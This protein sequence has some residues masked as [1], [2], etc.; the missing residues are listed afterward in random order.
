L[1]FLSP[2]LP[3]HHPKQKNTRAQNFAKVET[4]REELSSLSDEL[5]VKSLP[6]FKFYRNGKEVVGEVVG[7]KRKPLEDAVE[8]LSR[9]GA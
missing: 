3:K 7:Y 8:A 2:S 6:A 9:G 5:G 1:C 4:T